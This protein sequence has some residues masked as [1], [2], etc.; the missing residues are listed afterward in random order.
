MTGRRLL[1]VGAVLALLAVVSYTHVWGEP[2]APKDAGTARDPGIVPGKVEVGTTQD[3]LASRFTD[4]GAIS[5]TNQQGERLFALQAKPKLDQPPARPR[6]FVVMIDTSA[7]KANGPLATALKLTEKLV[8]QLGADDRICIRTA[9]L[10]S[11]DLTGGF[12]NKEDAREGLKALAQEVPLGAVDLHKCLDA[13]LSSF[14]PQAGRQQVMLYMGDGLSNGEPIK[15]EE[16]AKFTDQMV[17]DQIAFFPVPLGRRFD[18]QMLHGIATATGGAAVRVLPTDDVEKTIDTTVKRL[19]DT[20]SAPILYPTSFK[21]AGDVTESYPTRLPP[22]RSDA[23]TLIVGKLKGGNSVG[24]DVTGSVAGKEQHK[25]QT[26]AVPDSE[27]DNFFLIGMLRQWK[28]EGDA[29]ALLR[30]DRMLAVALETNR[31]ARE[32]LV[33][34][35]EMAL[36]QD[37]Y[38]AAERLFGQAAALDP[39]DSEAR[40]GLDVSRKLHDGKLTKDQLREQAAPK[41]GEMGVRIT[42]IDKTKEG[43]GKDY[44]QNVK[45]TREQLLKLADPDAAKP[46]LPPQQEPGGDLIKEAKQRQAVED[47][48]M[49]QIIDEAI[50]DAQRVLRVDPDAAH[51][52][53]KRA[54]E[55]IKT[56]PDVSEQVRRTLAQRLE[57]QLRSVDTQGVQIK[58]TLHEQ[59]ERAALAQQRFVADAATLASEERIAER[60]RVFHK[61]MNLAREQEA[62]RQAEAIRADQIALGRPIPPAVTAGIQIGQ[63]AYE[64]RE[65]NELRIQRQDRFLLTML[66]VERSHMPFPD[67]IGGVLDPNGRGPIEFP[68]AKLWQE[69][70]RFRKARYGTLSLTGEAAPPRTLELQDTLAKAVKFGGFEAD[71]KF[72]LGEALDFLADRFD[73]TFDVNEAAFKAEMVDDVLSKPV[74]EKAIPKMFN[75]SLE[76][77]LRRIL[78]RVPSTSGTTYIIRRDVIEI[79]TEARAAAEK[80][81][82]VYPVGD[83]VIP[84]PNAVNQAALNQAFTLFGNTPAGFQNVGQFG[85]QFQFGGQLGL[86]LGLQGGLNVGLNV[87]LNGGLNLGINLGL[88]GG[89]NLGVQLG[90]NQGINF[91]NN[92]GLNIG[93]NLGGQFGGVNIGFGNIGAQFGNLGAQFGFQGGGQERYLILMIRQVVGTPKDWAPLGGVNQVGNPAGPGG[94]PDDTVGD[95]GGSDLAYYPPAL[96]LVVKASSRIHIRAGSPTSGVPGPGAFLPRDGDK[97]NAIVRIE[98][99]RKG[100][101]DPVVKDDKKDPPKVV[102]RP[103]PPLHDKDPKEVWQE[104]LARGVTDPGL[105]I[106]TSDYLSQAGEFTHAAEFLKAE[107]R[108]GIV[109]EPWVYEAL[110]IALKESKAS[111]EEIDRAL[112]SEADL[113]PQDAKGFLKASQS[114]AAQKRYDLALALCR[115]A[116]RLEPDAPYAYQDAL[117]YAQQVKDTDA[118]EWAAANLLRRDWPADNADLHDR[119]K[120]RLTALAKESDGKDKN[121][122][123]KLRTALAASQERDLVF[124]LSWNGEAD[125]DLRV[126]EP[127]GSECS[128]LSRQTVGGGTLIGDT[129]S[130]PN[131]ETYVAG[132][133]FSGEYK[134]RI[135]RAWGTPTGGKA[136]LE[137][138]RH[139]G[140]PNE[141]VTPITVTLTENTVVPVKLED[142]RRTET[143]FVPPPAPRPTPP[144]ELGGIDRVVS[145]LRALAEGSQGTER[146]T[147]QADVGST[148]VALTKPTPIKADDKKSQ[149]SEQVVF[150]SKVSP[151]VFN[152]GVDLTAQ[153]TISADRRYVRL[154]LNP[155]LSVVTPGAISTPTVILPLLPG[156]GRVVPVP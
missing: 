78:S 81:T 21:L 107:L 8:D 114:M 122:A 73:L 10:S 49:T 110:A 82:R 139:Q 83:L 22:L 115:Q 65:Q 117:G 111:P 119:A 89:L 70:T 104:V 131:R 68:P 127:T 100:G 138:I 46:D 11:H 36:A 66:S 30:A 15:P 53:L 84:I 92:Q 116:A 32:E 63:A 52:N 33:A 39:G 31:N 155:N 50:R 105:I 79:T 87:G 150:Q 43:G 106:A 135:D 71:P 103:K 12:K 58:R 101:N 27:A 72:S 62:Q 48:R 86:N 40:A 38:D 5:Y 136:K 121:A 77:V 35:G 146:G 149:Q 61:L 152:G 88:N 153:G 120:D 51:D 17:K 128:W 44:R 16:R 80:V 95:P 124:R 154:S 141:T 90:L 156:G 144:A 147:A 129:L 108:Q 148:G 142:G 126:L 13:A 134:V 64:I 69:L 143:A 96:A 145:Q 112:V 4:Q 132:K 140:T 24:L 118:L 41:P 29:P 97:D 59:M 125:L 98:P 57:T 137:V 34:Q 151:F 76:T 23:P 1:A 67:E 55:S 99:R 9:N 74:A 85:G 123:T 109:V 28:D 3:M 93:N 56:N 130:E 47:Q 133:A 113:Q 19:F 91:G 45:V 42:K 54:L 7:S 2:T 60:M 6:D 94:N 20:V 75:V 26:E 14:K 37:K 25:V 102:E 18:P